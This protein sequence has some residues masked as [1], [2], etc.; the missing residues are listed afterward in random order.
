MLTVERLSI[1]YDRRSEI[2]GF[3]A[4]EWAKYVY[5]VT[6]KSVSKSGLDRPAAGH[7]VLSATE[8]DNYNN[9]PAVVKTKA[10]NVKFDGFVVGTFDDNL[11]VVARESRGLL[12]GVYDLLE[13]HLGVVFGGPHDHEEYVPR[14]ENVVIRHALRVKNPLFELRAIGFHNHAD[15]NFPD[16]P[17]DWIKML[18]WMAKRKFNAIQSFFEPYF[19][20][21]EKLLP[22]M[23]KRGF[24]LDLGCHSYPVLLSGEKYMA[25]RPD[26]FARDARGNLLKPENI[27]F[28]NPDARAELAA[29]A[30]A[31]LEAYP[32]VAILDLCPQDGASFCQC[33]RCAKKKLEQWL[34]ITASEITEN[35][36][37]RFPNM[38]FT[39]ISYSIYT[40][41][42]KD[43]KKLPQNVLIEFCDYWDRIGNRPLRDYR[44]GRR[45]LKDAEDMAKFQVTYVRD[46]RDVCEDLDGWMDFSGKLYMATYYGDLIIKNVIANIV[47]VI[48]SDASYFSAVGIAGFADVMCNP[49]KWVNHAL[50]YFALS[51][52]SWD[53][54]A[55]ER[56]IIRAFARGMFGLK[57]EKTIERYF[58]TLDALLN[59][60][61]HL[62]FNTFDLV[63]RA[64]K[65]TAHFAGVIDRLVT[66][67]RADFDAKLKELRR[68]VDKLRALP[69]SEI[70]QKAVAELHMATIHLDM[71]LRKKMAL[72]L[73]YAYQRKNDPR[74][75]E[76]ELGTAETLADAIWSS[77]E[78]SGRFKNHEAYLAEKELI[79]VLRRGLAIR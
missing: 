29:R 73:V 60:P 1:D 56:R 42:P 23:R 31:T 66:P 58:A 35:V 54:D 52:F 39:H 57:A 34:A 10:A 13:S 33:P 41:P 19:A 27:C 50:T 51:V 37:K 45:A 71:T 48:K 64:A 47:S 25:T 38:R 32:E 16:Y 4:T 30:L 74:R 9:L 43:V 14:K 28:S 6:G 62:G 63:H 75:A 8:D 67:T 15:L 72:Y 78:L 18:D 12:F 68:L 79:A 20:R 59:A 7:L 49:E 55:D 21:R 11:Y 44:Q 5:R 36:T 53:K 2:A 70:N 26:Y 24:I 22:E 76:E 40:R 61:C 46:H 77:T 3:A 17:F 65:E 69:A